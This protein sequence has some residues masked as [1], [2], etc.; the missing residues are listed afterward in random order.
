[1]RQPYLDRL[2]V[3]VSQDCNL[4]C[5]YCYADTGA[6][7]GPRMMM[8]DAV[9]TQTINAFYNQFEQIGRLQFFGGEPLLNHKLI[10]KLCDHVLTLCGQCDVPPPNFSL[11][12]NGTLLNEAIME[13]IADFGIMVTVSLDGDRSVH[14]Y[15]RIFADK[16]G[17]FDRVVENIL[18]LKQ[19]TGQPSQIE[20]TYHA[21]HL[22]SNF[23]MTEFMRFIAEQLDV[24]S[25]HMPWLLGDSYQK[26]GIKQQHNLI[27]QVVDVYKTAVDYSMQSLLQQDL[28]Q[29]ILLSY[30]DRAITARLLPQE[31]MRKTH[32]CPAGSGTLSVGSDG[33]IFP[34]F[35]FTNNKS[36]QFGSVDDKR[37][38]P[39]F[40]KRD[41]FTRQ[42]E[43]TK[44]PETATDVSACAGHNYENQDHIAS[45][46][47]GDK[48]VQQVL[49]E[50]IKSVLRKVTEDADTWSW[51]QTKYQLIKIY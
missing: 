7:G 24:H 16:R 3:N 17:S 39:V 40:E 50:Y 26:T 19:Y 48:H 34:C 14:D 13:M 35:M 44:L 38:E 51:V 1:M 4:R 31:G 9:G 37:W 29:T 18:K 43:L 28:Q 8:T 45:I 41:A 42:L 2:V 23:S 12:T 20:G 27:E 21:F 49:D 47:P 30:L 15:Y 11:V 5:A 25:L 46:G 33:K 6:Y 36:F 22:E 32:L 10:A